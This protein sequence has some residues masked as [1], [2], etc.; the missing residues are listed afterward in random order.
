MKTKLVVLIAIIW[1]GCYHLHADSPLTSTYMS[2]SYEDVPIVILAFQAEGKLTDELMDYIVD[3]ENDIDIRIAIVNALSWGHEGIENAE[4][5]LAYLEGI[6]M[7]TDYDDFTSNAPWDL[8]ICMAYLDA[9]DDYFNVRSAMSL[10]RKARSKNSNS[11]TVSIIC[12][13]IE[14]QIAMHSGMHNWCKAY[15]LTDQV[16]NDL[17]LKQDMREG[18]VNNIFEYMDVYESYCE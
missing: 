1:G 2:E 13:L 10:A 3:S 7:F 9:L 14:A 17:S 11:Y 6:G 12:A 5:F 18:A 8:L 16:R 15:N 4:I